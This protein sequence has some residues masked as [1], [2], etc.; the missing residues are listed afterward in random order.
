MSFAAWAIA[1]CVGEAAPPADL[2]VAQQPLQEKGVYYL[3]ATGT[4][5]T[6]TFTF[7]DQ[8]KTVIGNGRTS[9]SPLLTEVQWRGNKW[10]GSDGGFS[11]N[12]VAVGPDGADAV[13]LDTVLTVVEASHDQAFA[14]NSSTLNEQAQPNA[15]PPRRL[16]SRPNNRCVG[17]C[18]GYVCSNTTGGV[19]ICLPP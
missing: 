19:G 5:E 9:Q 12:G 18:T 16:C 8:N 14:A 2:Q 10:E 15:C 13:E 11:K 1:G 7:Y 3:G 17:A 4:A 6:A